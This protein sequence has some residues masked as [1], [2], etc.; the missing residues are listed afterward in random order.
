MKAERGL[1]TG[2]PDPLRVAFD[3]A[4]MAHF[5]PIVGGWARKRVLV[6]GTGAGPLAKVLTEAGAEAVPHVPAAPDP[7]AARRDLLPFPEASFDLVWCAALTAQPIPPERLL[8]EASRV[9]KHRGKLLYDAVNRTWLAR[10]LL[11]RVL[12][13]AQH[14]P[15]RFLTP[16]ETAEMLRAVGLAPR[17][18]TGLGP[19]RL[20]MRGAPVFGP[21]A[22]LSVVYA[23][24][25]WAD[26]PG[27]Y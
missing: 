12:R 14:D 19:N 2:R 1:E 9:L 18:L 15:A 8:A 13:R 24:W 23:G 6:L 17:G 5:G 20:T 11:V 7:A 25:A 3:A 27:I 4:R 10:L 21:V 16:E 26:K 22:A